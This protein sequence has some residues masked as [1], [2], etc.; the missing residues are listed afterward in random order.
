MVLRDE[1]GIPVFHRHSC[2][3]KR[4]GQIMTQ[5]EMQSFAVEVLIKQYKM[6]GVQIKKTQSDIDFSYERGNLTI[7]VKVL[8]QQDFNQKIKEFYDFDQEIREVDDSEL[9]RRYR[10]AG[11]IPHLMLASAFC[12][13]N[14]NGVPAVC[15]ENCRFQFYPV[16]LLPDEK[17]YIL[18]FEYDTLGLARIYAKAWNALDVSIIEPYLDKNFRYTSDCVF[19]VMPSRYEYI[20][21]LTAKFQAISESNSILKAQP[22]K[23]EGTNELGVL[24]HQD[25]NPD[26]EDG[27]LLIKTF[28]GRIL[29]ARMTILVQDEEKH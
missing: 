4:K 1:D 22:L 7:N 11:E 29:S 12:D 15:G 25:N 9:I 20:H 18:P 16:S 8:Y 23:M 2:S 3:S 19:E 26:G 13:A 21:Y 14:P 27:A 17:N 24:L 28:Q 10:E 5:E 6:C